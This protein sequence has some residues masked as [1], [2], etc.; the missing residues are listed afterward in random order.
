MEYTLVMWPESQVY[1][2][3]KWFN[4]EAILYQAIREEQDY[5]DSA[6]FIPTK[7]LK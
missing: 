1:M 2:D 4:K 5:L 3:E 7:Y 6:Y